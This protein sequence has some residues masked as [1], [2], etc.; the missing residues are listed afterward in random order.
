M[1]K[2]GYTSTDELILSTDYAQYAGYETRDEY[3]QA[4]IET[5]KLIDEERRRR[6]TISQIRSK[7]WERDLDTEFNYYQ[8]L[9]KTQAE[10]FEKTA[11]NLATYMYGNTD[12]AKDELAKINDIVQK[13]NEALQKGIKSSWR[14]MFDELQQ[15]T[16]KLKDIG[17]AQGILPEEAFF[18]ANGEVNNPIAD[19]RV[20]IYHPNGKTS[21]GYAK[22]E[23]PQPENINLPVLYTSTPSN[24]QNIE[25]AEIIEETPKDWR[26][27]PELKYRDWE[28]DRKS[29]RLNSSHEIPSRMPSSA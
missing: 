21:Y 3:E 2:Q 6:E 19:D 14:L 5:Q 18:G 8:K 28:T 16:K 11:K 15:Y 25:E 29:T 20:M 13:Y 10:F 26:K 12:Q 7:A 27:H 17:I 23:E 9:Y 24:V 1:I 4:K 22:T